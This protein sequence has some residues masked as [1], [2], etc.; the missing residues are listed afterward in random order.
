MGRILDFNNFLLE[1]SNLKIQMDEKL[2]TS[3]R[4]NPAYSLNSE[5]EGYIRETNNKGGNSRLAEKISSKLI[6]KYKE[7][8][9]EGFL[10]GIPSICYLDVFT[11][12]V[13]KMGLVE[14]NLTLDTIL[15]IEDSSKQILKRELPDMLKEWKGNNGFVNILKN[16]DDSELLDEHKIEEYL[17]EETMKRAKENVD[18]SDFILDK[19]RSIKSIIT[20]RDKDSI[21]QLDKKDSELLKFIFSQA[22]SDYQTASKIRNNTPNFYRECSEYV[23]LDDADIS[24]NLGSFGF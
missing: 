7:K 2:D 24:A 14:K 1:N 4:D 5:I 10:N 17:S 13:A 12:L 16:T 6:E 8:I 22:V 19:I 11:E 9:F 23:G 3:Y 21:S 18:N 15:K 20:S